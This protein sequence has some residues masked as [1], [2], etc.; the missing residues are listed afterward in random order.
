[1]SN[2]IFAVLIGA[3]VILSG[4]SNDRYAVESQYWRLKK[5]AE[6]IF[7]NPD[8]SPPNQLERTV[9]LLNGF[10]RKYPKSALSTGAEFTIANLYM[11][12]KEYGQARAQLKSIIG[13]YNASDNIRADALFLTGN[14]YEMEDKW[15]SALQVYKKIISEYPVTKRGFETPARIARYY[16]IK[17]QPEKMMLAYQ[18]AARHYLVLA[19]KHPGSG[20]GFNSYHLAARCYIS[21]KDWQNAINTFETMAGNYKNKVKMDG[22]LMN[23]ALIYNRE[24]KDKAKYKETL[25]RLIKDYPDS[26]LIKRATG[27][28]K[29]LNKG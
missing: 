14:S 1:M 20:I 19:N 11:A 28:L 4:C 9:N 21:M 16:K 24:L 3:S 23:M 22:V 6:K 29:E 7:N 2:L 8:A 10:I 27:L 13:K 12:K 17:Y 18:E 5:Q 26:K 25:E 15:D